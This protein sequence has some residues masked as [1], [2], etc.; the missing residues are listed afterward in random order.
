MNS[1]KSGVLGKASVL[2]MFVAMSVQIMTGCNA[3]NTT[4]GGAIGAGA[5]G[6]IGG[7]IGSRSGNTAVG[8]IIGAT[9][10]GA[11]G[12]LIGRQM[13]KQAEEL[14]RD[15]E[16]AKVERVGEGIKITFNSG[17]L[18][19]VNSSQLNATTQGNLR[20]LA[21][22][23]NKY[24]DTNILIEGHTDNTGSDDYNQKLS[25]ARARSVAS[26]LEA[27]NVKNSRVTTIGYGETQPVAD[28]NS[29]AGRDQNRRVEVAIYANKKMKKWAEKNEAG[30][31]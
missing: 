15:L 28:N 11:A 9:V 3:T 25:E 31:S 13:D 23:L 16:G 22:T 7:V 1:V 26:Y 20:E 8:A 30:N 10:G 14:K 4:K 6:A 5:G 19:N 24:E 21:A 18:F 29:D 17:L 27:Q 2:F 12:A